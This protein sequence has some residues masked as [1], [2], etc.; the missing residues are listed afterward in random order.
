MTYA[1][2]IQHLILMVFIKLLCFVDKSTIILPYKLFFAVK[3]DVL[4]ELDKL[5][6][7]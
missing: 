1:A 4:S 2:A 7:L 5:G 3:G 6:Q